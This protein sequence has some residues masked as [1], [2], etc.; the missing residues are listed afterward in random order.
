MSRKSAF[1]PQLPYENLVA[2]VCGEKWRTLENNEIDAAWGVAVV[3]SILD[4]IDNEPREI[5]NHL[6]VDTG[7]IYD[8]WRRLMMNGALVTRNLNRDRRALNAGDQLAWGYYAG[9]AAG[10][11]GPVRF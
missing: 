6:G 11:V 2:G 8:A 3:R 1:I 4:G 9:Y 7:D 10:A 5:A